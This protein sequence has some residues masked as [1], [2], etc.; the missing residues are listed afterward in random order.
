MGE[1][2][3]RVAIDSQKIETRTFN[4][5]RTSRKDSNITENK[6]IER[7]YCRNFKEGRSKR[8][9][10]MAQEINDNVDNGEKIWKLNRKLEKKFQAPYSIKMTEG[11]DHIYSKNIQKYYK[12]KLKTRECETE[13]EFNKKFQ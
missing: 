1:R 5:N 9:N 11:I 7:A 13:E 2:Y 3:Q 12:T 4:H 8:I 6:K 10:P